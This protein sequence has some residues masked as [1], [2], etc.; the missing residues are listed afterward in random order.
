MKKIWI[1]GAGIVLTV[2]IALFVYAKVQIQK[3]AREKTASALRSAGDA[4]SKARLRHAFVYA[5]ELF[6][7]GEKLYNSAMQKWKDENSRWYFS[8]DF[9]NAIQLANNAEKKANYALKKAGEY[10]NKIQKDLEK[11]LEELSR[12]VKDFEAFY[13]VIPLPTEVRSNFAKGRLLFSESKRIGEKGEFR[14]ALKKAKDAELLISPAYH[15]GKDK[16]Y[17]YFNSFLKWEKLNNDAFRLSHSG[18]VIMV[19]KIARRCYIYKNGKVAQ[20]FIAELGE[21]WVGTKNKQGD[22]STP[23][24][25]YYITKK[26]KGSQTI[27]YKALLI[28]YPNDE[29]KERFSKNKV[30]G[31]IPQSAKIGNLIEIHGGGGR[32]TDW[33]EGCVALTDNDMDKIFPLVEVGTPVFIVGSLVPLEKLKTRDTLKSRN[34]E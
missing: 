31:A 21:N 19:D 2:V 12:K 15:F 32:G 22:K 24:G 27:Y 29:D 18:R 10:R 14:L 11:L 34:D 26:L 4:I 20:T 1:S 3:S 30:S 33:T 28:N 13:S 6:K 9:D 25:K 23:E 17:T 16:L 7:E 8:R 5:P